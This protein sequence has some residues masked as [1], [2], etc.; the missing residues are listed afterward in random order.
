MRR[1]EKS[2]RFLVVVVV[3]AGLQHGYYALVMMMT[4]RM[5]EW[6]KK[7]LDSNSL[8]MTKMNHVEQI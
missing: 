1:G 6:K 7:V 3:V 8:T 5:T 2:S 4:T